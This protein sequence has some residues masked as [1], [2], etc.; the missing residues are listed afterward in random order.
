MHEQYSHR[1]KFV[2]IHV[3]SLSR[4]KQYIQYQN[5]GFRLSRSKKDVCNSCVHLDTK[6]LQSDIC[7]ER[8][9]IILPFFLANIAN[10]PLILLK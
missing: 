10:I 8:P 4:W 2:S 7:E 5:P 6:L 1:A 3:L 9:S